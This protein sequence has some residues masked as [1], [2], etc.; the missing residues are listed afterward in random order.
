MKQKISKKKKFIVYLMLLGLTILSISS[1][2]YIFPEIGDIFYNASVVSAQR[3]DPVEI[4]CV[5]QS[6]HMNLEEDSLNVYIAHWPS[7]DFGYEEN[8]YANLV[9]EGD[10]LTECYSKNCSYI[11]GEGFFSEPGTYE[12]SSTI[13]ITCIKGPEHY[14][15]N[16]GSVMPIPITVSEKPYHNPEGGDVPTAGFMCSK[17]ENG[18]WEAC[19]DIVAYE[20]DIIYLRDNPD[21]GGESS[22]PGQYQDIEGRIWKRN[23]VVFD[24]GCDGCDD[25]LYHDGELHENSEVQAFYP[26]TEITL[27]LITDLGI[28]ISKTHYVS[29]GEEEGLLFIRW[30]EKNPAEY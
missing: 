15:I 25:F 12:V 7:C 28:D 19:E 23:G 10:L 17:N 4:Y 6:C 18:P 5:P 21:T 8:V 22:L 20:R 26:I 1:S 30:V 27:T 14:G 3:Y 9:Y 24:A 29:S 11:L 2:V 13:N 16:L